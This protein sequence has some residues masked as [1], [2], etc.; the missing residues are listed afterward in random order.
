MRA[1]SYFSLALVL[2]LSVASIALLN[3]DLGFLR[4]LYERVASDTLQREVRIEGPLSVRLGATLTISAN[5]IDVADRTPNAA[6]LATI[7][8]LEIHLDL[9][10]LLDNHIH[11]PFVAIRGASVRL[12]ID[13]DGQGNW[14]ELDGDSDPSDAIGYALRVAEGQVDAFQLQLRNRSTDR[15]LELDIKTL[16]S[17]QRDK[18]VQ[19]SGAGTLNKRPFDT[20][21]SL[22]NVAS[23]LEVNQWEIDWQGFIGAATFQSSAYIEAVDQWMQS[24]LSASLHTNSANELLTTLSLPLIDDGPVD[25]AITL[26]PDLAATVLDIDATFGEFQI[27]GLAS[28][29]TP[30]TL[31]SGQVAMIA[32]GPDLAQLG[33]FFGEKNWPASAFQANV[34][35]SLRN[36]RVEIERFELTS[37]AVTISLIGALPDYRAPG[38]GALEGAIYIPSLAVL[39]EVLDL[40]KSLQGPLNGKMSLTRSGQGTDVLI[41]SDTPFLSFEV[42]GRIEPGESMLGSALTL[43]GH[44]DTTDLLLGLAVDNPPPLPP[45]D[46]TGKFTI[47]APETL[48]TR[49]LRVTLGDDVVL[50]E[51]IFG[52]SHA[53]PKTA[54]SLSIESPN[55][56]ST[57]AEWV[58]APE[59]IPALPANASGQISYS[60]SDTL[61]I[62]DGSANVAGGS[63]RFSG[64][65]MLRGTAP[66]ISGNWN[67]QFPAIQPLLTTAE[68]PPH[69]EKPVAFEGEATWQPGKVSIDIAEGQLR[70]GSTSFAGNLSLDLE[71]ETMRFDVESNTPDITDY[72]PDDED[73]APAFSVPMSLRAVGELSEEA[74]SVEALQIESTQAKIDSSGYLELDGD[75]FVNS[76]L[77]SFI[78]IAS[79]NVFDELTALALPDQGLVVSAELDS[80]GGALVIERLKLISGE[81]DLSLTGRVEN[82]EALKV[83]FTAVSEEIN[84]TPWITMLAERQAAT[85]KKAPS[86]GDAA[87]NDRLIPDVPLTFDWP[88]AVRASVDVSVAKIS[89][90][91]RPVLSIK[92]AGQVDQQGVI[93]ESLSAEN[94]RGGVSHLSGEFLRMPGG[95]PR[96]NVKIDG[97][98][99]LLGI[100]KA[101]QEEVNSLP[102]YAVKARL[103]GSGATAR[104]LASNLS[105]YINVTMD[106]G[107]VLNT[108]LDLLTNSFVQELSN[109]LNPFQDQQEST[110]INC[111]AAFTSIEKGQ[112]LGKP[113]VVVDT[114][115]VKILADLALNLES[116][117]IQAQFKTAPQKGLGF[118][119]SSL[120]NP[121]V[122]VTGTLG[123]P[124]LSLNPAN[125]IVGGSIAVMTGGVSILVGNLVQRVTTSGNICSTRLRKANEEMAQLDAAG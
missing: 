89:G 21:L 99:L 24:R 39:S 25:I 14:P 107:K 65:V 45:L 75:A 40:P 26:G 112:M 92:G 124:R 52:W 93:I 69:F 76:H 1:L 28:S 120:V 59:Q 86:E 104:E 108:G 115:N 27:K 82:P 79:L 23:L 109:A 18:S 44:S 64:T 16:R 121:Y 6:S 100:P 47:E 58:P 95:L 13:D 88:E 114:P 15:D 117:K 101:P 123:K 35:T 56:R 32:S 54:I 80:R 19:L 3:L 84:L 70:Y 55:L 29:E 96:L 63:G 78:T 83:E 102:P 10:P 71:A 61:R 62:T 85:P 103:T 57:L 33:A 110:K 37:D 2:V 67:V 30:D 22:N 9:K 50:A 116:E 97:S 12:E 81:S 5:Q 106:E 72:A 43:T 48:R 41:K 87:G 77:N 111:A 8:G 60:S 38:S 90:L 113:A 53:L 98:E 31:A 11:I 7:D 17:F 34:D 20:T 91:A 42:G 125:T 4:P 66:T 105:G 119:M 122:E 74:W 46:F 36:F 73:L 68:V 94:A 51:G 49:D 118:S